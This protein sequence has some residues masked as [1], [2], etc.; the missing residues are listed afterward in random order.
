MLPRDEY[1]LG[2]ETPTTFSGP[3]AS[4]AIAATT[5]E[6]IPPLRPSTADLK[7]HFP[8]VIAQA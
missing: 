7:P 8:Q 4:T 5:A 2:I 3:S 6:S 1:W